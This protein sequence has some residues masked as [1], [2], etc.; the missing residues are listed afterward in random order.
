MTKRVFGWFSRIF[1]AAP[2]TAAIAAALATFATGVAEAVNKPLAVWNGDFT[3]G[4]DNA[5]G[6]FYLDL[7][8]GS[9]T[10]NLTTFANG[11]ITIGSGAAGG[12]QVSAQ[13]TSTWKDMTVVVGYD[14]SGATISTTGANWP[15]LSSATT[16]R[17]AG[18]ISGIVFANG[19]STTANQFGF[20]WNGSESSGAGTAATGVSQQVPRDGL[21][22]FAD[23]FAV[24]VNTGGS[25]AYVDGVEARYASAYGSGGTGYYIKGMGIGGYYS[26]GSARNMPGA[27]ISYIAVFA[28]TAGTHSGANGNA[29]AIAVYSPTAMTSAY[30]PATGATLSS[31]DNATLAAQGINLPADGYVT[32][33]GDVTVAAVFAQGNSEIRFADENSSLTVSGPVYV[34]DSYTI[35]VVPSALTTVDTAKT[36]I[37]ATAIASASNVSVTLPTESGYKYVSSVGDTAVTLTRAVKIGLDYTAAPGGGFYAGSEWFTSFSYETPAAYRVGPS[38]TYPIVYEMT[39][40]NFNPYVAY[41]ASPGF[42]FAIYAD[43]SEITANNAVVM[44]FGTAAN[45]LILYKNDDSNGNLRL[46]RST[47][48]N[49]IETG[50]LQVA[51]P[52]AGFHLY[53][54]TCGTDGTLK[55][56]IDDGT[57]SGT[58]SMTTTTAFGTGFQVGSTYGGSIDWMNSANGMAVA[59][60]L[61]W[62]RVL[63]AEEVTALSAKYPAT[64]GTIDRDIILNHSGKTLKVYSSEPASGISPVLGVDAGTANIPSGEEVTVAKV[65]FDPNK[66]SGDA[67][68]VTVGGTLNV[69]ASD[70]ATGSADMGVTLGYWLDNTLAGDRTSTLTVSSGGVLNAPNAYVQMP[71]ATFCQG[72]AFNVNGTATVKG[73]YSNQAGKGTVTLANGGTLEVSEILSSGQAI[74]KNF[75]YGTFRILADATETRAINFSAVNGYATTLD[76]NGH[77]LTMTAAA[78]TGSSAVTVGG[79]NGGT[80]VFQGWTSP[81][82]GEL[83]FTD[84]NSSMIQVSSWENF[85]GTLTGTITIDDTNVSKLSFATF[86][87]DRFTGTLNYAVTGGTLDLREYDMSASTINVTGSGATVQLSAGQEGTLNVSAGATGALYTDEEVY[88]YEGHIYG[89]GTVAGTLEYYYT[90]DSGST[91]TAA[92]ED[93]YNGNNL[94]P[95]YYV[96]T[97]SETESENTISA[98]AADRWKCA[99]LPPDGKNV[100]FKLSGNTT[101]LVDGTVSYGDVQVYGTGT[102]TF[103]TSGG[104]AITVTDKLQTTA[105]TGLQIDSGL[106]FGVGSTLE[107]VSTLPMYMTAV[108][109]G[110]EETPYAIP[111]ISGVGSV[112]VPAGK[113]LALS[114]ADMGIL[115]VLG[116]VALTG[117]ATVDSISVY[118]SGLLA[119][120][121]AALAVET[122]A[123]FEGSVTV[124][125]ASSLAVA[126]SITGLGRVEYTGRLPDGS[127]WATGTASSGWR[128]TLAIKDFNYS[129]SNNWTPANYGNQYSTLEAD[130]CNVYYFA[131]SGSAVL[132]TL[133][134]A[135][136]L[137]I[138][139]GGSSDVNVFAGLSGSGTLKCGTGTV[140]QTLKFGTAADFAGSI[141]NISFKLV[142]GTSAGANSTITVDSGYVLALADD[143]SLSSTSVVLNGTLNVAGSGELTGAVTAGGSAKIALADEPLTING[144]L[145]ATALEIDTG[146]I[147]LSETPAPVV[148]GL[149]AEPSADTLAAI[150]VEHCN[151]TAAEDSGFWTIFAAYKSTAWSGGSGDWTASE[152]NGGAVATDGDDV[153]FVAG[154]S[155]AVA[156]A[157]DG[158][159]AP[160]NVAF[161][162]GSTTTYTLSGGAFEP[163]GTV[164]IKSGTVTIESVATGTYVVESGATLSLTNATVTSVSGAGTL[165]IPSGGVVT[166]ASATALDSLSCITGQGELHVGANI[167]GSTLNALLKKSYTENEATA[168]YWQGTVVIENLVEDNSTTYGGTTLDC[169]NVSSTIQLKNTTIRYF[170]QFTTAADLEIV[171]TVKTLDGSGTQQTVFGA[172]KGTGSLVLENDVRHLYRFTSGEEFAGTLEVRGRRVVFG[173]D[174]TGSDTTDRD[175]YG[176]TIRISAGYAATLGAG[177]HWTA[178]NGIIISGE[179]TVKGTESYLEHN[180]SGTY[181]IVFND[182]ATIGFK[183]LAALKLGADGLRTP[184]VAVGSTVNIAFGTEVD[185]SV[186]A[187]TTLISWGGAPNGEFAFADSTLADDYCLVKTASGLVVS[188]WGEISLTTDENVTSVTGVADGDKVKPGDTVSFTVATA[189]AFEPVVVVDGNALEPSDGV[190]SFTVSASGT[191]AID[192]SS[193]AAKLMN[194]NDEEAGY[195]SA[196]T[197]MGM[198]YVV[199]YVTNTTSSVTVPAAAQYLRLTAPDGAANLVLAAGSQI[200]SAAYIADIYATDAN[201]AMDAS[202]NINA[203]AFTISFTAATAEAEG[204]IT[205]ALNASGSVRYATTDSAGTKQVTHSVTPAVASSSPMTMDANAV[206]TFRVETIPGLWYAVISGTDTEHADAIGTPVRATSSETTSLTAADAPSSG[207]LYYKIAVGVSKAAVEAAVSPTPQP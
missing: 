51:K 195:L 6:G 47:S 75:R 45:G 110:T 29:A 19:G 8:N 115:H 145:T 67:A 133:K 82:T 134:L 76:P 32:I 167:P 40:Q 206:P 33:S 89:T 189:A 84:A 175:N 111:T 60:I 9:A 36:L 157:L 41:T 182:G 31:A 21:F 156:V 179:L 35:T 70:A 129:S 4:T 14:L 95:Y 138:N 186:L 137:T 77:T 196:V 131:N 120:S 108:N 15:V 193:S 102:L 103:Q 114:G 42:S 87:W 135:G 188:E 154:Y 161:T 81:F 27:V 11:V 5:R 34:A 105:T 199:A 74:T 83:Q 49:N 44:A 65:H 197:E 117:N 149:T 59:K 23:E 116:K 25:C 71:W 56:Y 143:K 64:A 112:Y 22:Y 2:H 106:E 181:G 176:N 207:A 198:T 62:D 99:S 79:S 16:T 113:V 78:M 52:S 46:G 125:A 178:Y 53:T 26:T 183:A 72:A 153:S 170:N 163:A 171:G 180:N 200:A 147:A 141:N 151:I 146:S 66:A 12:V 94:L 119:L 124:D 190:Y 58:G 168:Y 107:V 7:N 169:G 54:V 30:S 24:A 3:F 130:N 136:N 88:K 17:Q 91:Y 98:N 109:C 166:L 127:L 10:E 18:D 57:V 96:W 132:P 101:V 13:S 203:S 37:L 201:G 20:H 90:A 38:A 144:T 93:A 92:A 104:G 128:G 192:V 155:G 191:I 204:S 173:T 172:L 194:V 159:R 63:T 122:T 158:T 150:I 85:A 39:A 152:F 97:P 121:G 69:T 140:R 164:T 1:G 139:N 185:T 174:G 55:L 165:N 61:G 160:A 142:V 68:A 86:P 80:V 205:I 177:S 118:E 73:L 43:L 100:A 148:T 123:S 48:N 28:G 50:Y 162:G 126:T 202:Q 184:T 187:G